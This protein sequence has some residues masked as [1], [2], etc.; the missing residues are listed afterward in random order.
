MAKLIFKKVH[1]EV[2]DFTCG[3]ESIDLQIRNAFFQSNLGIVYAYEASEKALGVVGYYCL[4]MHEINPKT[5]PD[6]LSDIDIGRPF[7]FY[8]VE[9]KFLAVKRN[10]QRQTLGTA[11][12]E[13][14]ITHLSIYHKSIPFR[15]IFIDALS[16]DEIVSWYERHG[17]Q[18]F[19]NIASG[20]FV[21]PMYLDLGT[22]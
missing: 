20:D 11:I 19:K 16:N 13:S 6:E 22:T 17:F 12:L 5:L 15:F 8:A 10:L 4:W 1:N 18:S 21:M 14:I 7:S 9:L 2:L 3:N